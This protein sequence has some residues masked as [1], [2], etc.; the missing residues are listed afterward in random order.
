MRMRSH[1]R[2]HARVP[3]GILHQLVNLY[4]TP[5]V[6][7]KFP[8]G[9]SDINAETLATRCQSL[10]HLLLYGCEAV[11][12]AGVGKMAKISRTHS[13]TQIAHICTEGAGDR[14]TEITSSGVSATFSMLPQAPPHE[15]RRSNLL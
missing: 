12:D 14:H 3:K 6:L 9:F 5:L 11:L 10:R 13:H 4:L 1:T 7:G 2:T 15:C 8:G